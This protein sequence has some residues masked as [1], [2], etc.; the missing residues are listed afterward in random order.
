M[1]CTD[2]MAFPGSAK[3]DLLVRRNNELGHNHFFHDGVSLPDARTDLP[4]DLVATARCMGVL[5]ICAGGHR[6]RSQCFYGSRPR[7]RRVTVTTYR[8]CNLVALAQLAGY[9]LDSR[10]RESLSSRWPRL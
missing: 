3:D 8:G 10:L 7:P 4:I 5:S 6:N 2:S 1:F 9:C